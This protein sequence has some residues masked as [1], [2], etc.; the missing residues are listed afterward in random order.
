M[1]CDITP[2]RIPMTVGFTHNIDSTIYE[3]IQAGVATSDG[4][5]RRISMWTDLKSSIG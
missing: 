1:V 4:M 2:N 3:P 5:S